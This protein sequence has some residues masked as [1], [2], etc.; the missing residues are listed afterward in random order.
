[1]D[2][3]D[4]IV[5]AYRADVVAAYRDAAEF[6]RLKAIT[7]DDDAIFRGFQ[8][9]AALIG[10]ATKRAKRAAVLDQL[11][12]AKARGL[13]ITPTVAAHA[14]ERILGRGVSNRVLLKSFGTEGRTASEKS[15]VGE[16]QLADVE[17]FC[18]AQLAQLEAA[19]K[20]VRADIKDEYSD[21]W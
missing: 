9:M 11:L 12:Q 4:Q 6:R 8:R 13:D 19:L 18:V 5:E 2:T 21:K 10:A 20:A 7:D 3:L 14:F 15:R 16:A 1:M 17:A